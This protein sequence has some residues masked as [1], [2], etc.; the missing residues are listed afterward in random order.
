MY[1]EK[2]NQA[3]DQCCFSIEQIGIIGKLVEP[4]AQWVD[5]RIFKPEVNPMQVK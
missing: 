5:Q 4:D 3:D 1:T 2:G